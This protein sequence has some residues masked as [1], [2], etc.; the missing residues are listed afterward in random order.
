MRAAPERYRHA[1]RRAFDR[2][3]PA[4]DS[5]AH[6]QREALARLSAF[7]AI[8]PPNPAQPVRRVLDA[9]CGTGLALP[10]LGG[11][12][13]AAQIFAVDFAPA[14]L[15]RACARGV[16]GFHSC[17]P[18]CA[19]IEQLPFADGTLDIYCSNLAVQWCDPARVLGEMARTLVPGGTAWI[20]T[21][22]GQ[23]LGEL[24]AAFAAVDDFPHVLDF[25]EGKDWREA[26][27]TARLTPLEI[28]RDAFLAL[29][30]D[31]RALLASIKA[32]GAQ[33]LAPG[34]RRRALGRRGWRTLQEA[35]ETFRRPDG[36]LP[37]TYDLTLIALKKP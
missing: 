10:W 37:A 22:G 6:V 33:T 30:P 15:A 4:Y 7:A 1:V 11:R 23:T 19:D 31:L 13:P 5:A 24:R 29:A 14:M 17:F 36:L 16:T 35:Y 9:G 12:F 20:A 21:L 18:L 8:H 26:A 28:R 3:A 27:G 32:I 25:V 34:H 2:A